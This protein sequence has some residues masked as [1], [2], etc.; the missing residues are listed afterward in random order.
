MNTTDKHG[1]DDA[2]WAAQERGMRAAP[3]A[4]ASG[5]DAIAATYR[6]VAEALASM[7]RSQ[8]PPD[9]V[10]EVAKRAARRE[11]GLERPLSRVLLALFLAVSA[12]MLVLYAEPAWRGLREALGSEA[13]GWV[14]AG[15]GCLALS[16]TGNRAVG[17]GYHGGQGARPASP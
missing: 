4:D 8:P 13:L 10:A 17:Y 9:F 3:D 5:L 14:L 7:P 12:G 11:S 6:V 1:I 16:W 2:E 15:V